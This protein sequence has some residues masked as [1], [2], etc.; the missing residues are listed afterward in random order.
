MITTN[1]FNKQLVKLFGDRYVTNDD[2][3]GANKK[4]CIHCSKCGNTFMAT[5]SSLK[6]GHGCPYCSGNHRYSND[7]YLELVRK[8]YGKSFTVLGKYTTGRAKILIKCNK[9]ENVEGVQASY[10]L[11]SPY[12]CPICDGR[13]RRYTTSTFKKK[14]SMLFNGQYTMLGEYSGTFSKVL[15]KC[16][17][18]GN[19]SY[20]A[21]NQLIQG[22]G[23]SYCAHNRRY[24]QKTATKEVREVSGGA[25]S[26]VGTYKNNRTKTDIKCNICGKTWGATLSNLKKGE[27]CPYC[28]GLHKYSQEEFQSLINSTF[29]GRYLV[30]GTYINS[31]TPIDILCNKCGNQWKVR[32][33]NILAGKGCPYCRSSKGEVLIKKYLDKNGIKYVQQKKF[34]GLVD[35]EPLSYD[36]FLPDKRVLIEYQGIQHFEPVSIFGGSAQLEVQ[37]KHDTA[38]RK[39]AKRHGYLML[40]PSYILDTYDGISSYL[41]SSLAFSSDYQYGSEHTDSKS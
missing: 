32:P 15:I 5:P 23:C 13:V 28:S 37:I 10:F 34:E 31:D 27:G 18:C 17:K 7:E 22:H 39:Y 35:K 16:N 24:T 29:N 20:M 19:T 40:E 36:F 6:S 3:Q 1:E 21:P 38:K 33:Y 26:L 2:Y 9:C 8:K 30:T 41:S 14:L 11:K 25:Y 4:L 12:K